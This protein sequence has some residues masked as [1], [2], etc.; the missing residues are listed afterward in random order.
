MKGPR[1]QSKSSISNF[2]ALRTPA[3]LQQPEQQYSVEISNKFAAP[4]EN[5][6]SAS[7][8]GG[9]DSYR[10]RRQSQLFV[11]PKIKR[12]KE[13]ERERDGSVKARL[14]L[15]LNKKKPVQSLETLEMI[16]I[17]YHSVKWQ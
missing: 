14:V 17:I 12:Q 13:R 4:D 5:I 16:T 6:S 9:Y 7:I 1:K 2:S 15:C 3:E 11:L 10:N 8:Q